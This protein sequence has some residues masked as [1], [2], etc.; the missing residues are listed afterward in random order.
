MVQ[1]L[2]AFS[3]L[4][5]IFFVQKK[6]LAHWGI[7][8]NDLLA[9][10]TITYIVV[11]KIVSVQQFRATKSIDVRGRTLKEAKF[12]NSVQVSSMVNNHHFSK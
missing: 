10:L 1:F 12:K 2:D 8:K 5:P 4:P 6:N 9:L 7:K 11:E 3:D